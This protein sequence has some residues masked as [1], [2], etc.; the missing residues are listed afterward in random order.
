MFAA[1]LALDLIVKLVPA[2]RAFILYTR[3]VVVLQVMPSRVPRDESSVTNIWLLTVTAVV[4]TTRVEPP[5]AMATLPADAALQTA[6]DAEELQ[7]V[8]VDAFPQEIVPGIV[9]VTPDF[10]IVM[11]VVVEVP[12]LRVPAVEVSMLYAAGTVMLL[13]KVAGPLTVRGPGNVVVIP[14]LPIVIEVAFVVPKLRAPPEMVSINEPICINRFPAVKVVLE[15]SSENRESP[16]VVDAVNFVSLFAVPVP[17][18]ESLV[19]L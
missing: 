14:V 6:G 5:V 8:V 12:M 16:M 4:F 9:A 10:P 17:V 1:G 3:P 19:V 18:T 7:L 11:A 2:V 13:P 15:P